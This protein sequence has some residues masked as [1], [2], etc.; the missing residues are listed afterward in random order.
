MATQATVLTEETVPLRLEEDVRRDEIAILAYELWNE[1]G[2]EI[3]SPD[4]AWFEAE[5]RRKSRRAQAANV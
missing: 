3:G 1:R 2:C 4:Q 5:R